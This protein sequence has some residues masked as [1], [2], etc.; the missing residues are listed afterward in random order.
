ML[1][2]CLQYQDLLDGAVVGAEACL[3]GCVEI[4]VASYFGE[5]LVHCCHEQLCER[6]GYSNASVIFWCSSASFALVY[7]LDF[8]CSPPFRWELV[9]CALI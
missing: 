5:S 3:G 4:Q 2:D 9:D 8:G 1:Q 7:G 6:W